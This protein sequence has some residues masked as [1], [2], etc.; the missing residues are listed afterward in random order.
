ML[1]VLFE[2]LLLLGVKEDVCF[3]LCSIRTLYFYM[4]QI[5]KLEN[6]IKDLD[7]EIK[8]NQSLGLSS[9]VKKYGPTPARKYR[10]SLER[11]S[12]IPTG[13]FADFFLQ[14]P[15]GFCRIRCLSGIF[16]AGSSGRNLRPGI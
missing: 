1:R 13:N 5:G 11:G 8:N 12:S 3:P 4:F 2:E 10:K 15:A 9:Q 16:S 6:K 14:F 7:E